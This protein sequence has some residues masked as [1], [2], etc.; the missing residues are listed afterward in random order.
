VKEKAKQ[1]FMPKKTSKKER[2]CSSIMMLKAQLRKILVQ[3]TI[4]SKG[5]KSENFCDDFF[6]TVVGFVNFSID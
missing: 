3:N 2:N 1:S 4:L 6:V 5:Q